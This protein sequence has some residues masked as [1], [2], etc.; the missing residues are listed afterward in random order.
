VKNSSTNAGKDGFIAKAAGNVSSK[1]KLM[2][3]RL[4]NLEGSRIH[5]KELSRFY[6][7]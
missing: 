2:F 1:I 5:K 3:G 4:M 6:I 7:K